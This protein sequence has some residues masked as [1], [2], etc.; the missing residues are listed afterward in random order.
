MKKLIL[1]ISFIFVALSCSTDEESQSYYFLKVPIQEVDI[2]EEFVMGQT[3][4][5]TVWYYKTSSCNNFDQI[6]YEQS[7][8]TRTIA[9][10]NYVLDRGGCQEISELVSAS[11][12]FYVTSNGSY[13]FKFWQGANSS[14]GDVYY[15]VE[16]PVVY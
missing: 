5:I 14:L 16:V 7:L 12:D 1:F 2:P 4:K 10:Q 15:E 9:V 13:V 8:N 6:L 11:F 3:Y